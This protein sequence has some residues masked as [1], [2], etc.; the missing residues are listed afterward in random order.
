[1][2][3]GVYG[4]QSLRSRSLG[5]G[6]SILRCR[7]RRC[8]PATGEQRSTRTEQHARGVARCPADIAGGNKCIRTKLDYSFDYA[9]D[10]ERPA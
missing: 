5:S 3:S 9:R 4:F 8:R 2:E 7:E 10:G 1:M 6:D